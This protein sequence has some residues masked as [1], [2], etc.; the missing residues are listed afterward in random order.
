MLRLVTIFLSLVPTNTFFIPE[1]PM[2]NTPVTHTVNIVKQHANVCPDNL[3]KITKYIDHDTGEKVIK[4]I[5][6]ALP[7]IDGI[8]GHILH[9]HDVIINYILNA[10]TLPP[11]LKKTIVLKLIEMVQNGDNAGS[12]LLQLYHDLVNCL[13]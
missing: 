12:A 1:P 9:A 4:T 10:D 13:L 5:S 3:Y 6:G 8:A 11:E 7:K 2:I